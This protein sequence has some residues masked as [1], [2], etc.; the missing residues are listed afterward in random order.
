MGR[1]KVREEAAKARAT[2]EDT[3]QKALNAIQ[4]GTMSLRD[5]ES[6]FMIPPYST[7]RGRQKGAKPHFVAHSDQQL[8]TPTDEKSVVRW[9]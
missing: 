9:I 4:A 2:R 6:A 7:L 1:V 8:L 3:I 5:A